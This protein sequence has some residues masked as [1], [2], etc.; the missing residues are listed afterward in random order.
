MVHTDCI[1]SNTSFPAHY[2]VAATLFTLCFATGANLGKISKLSSPLVTAFTSP[3]E[4]I[5]LIS[6]TEIS[7]DD[8]G[9]DEDKADGCL[10]QLDIYS[11]QDQSLLD[12]LQQHNP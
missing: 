11:D 2:E 10:E 8:Y 6:L 3:S 7:T 4:G 12:H 5:H 1:L 9:Q